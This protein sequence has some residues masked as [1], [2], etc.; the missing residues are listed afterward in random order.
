MCHFLVGLHFLFKNLDFEPQLPLQDEK[1]EYTVQDKVFG[2]FEWQYENSKECHF[3][4]FGELSRGFMIGKWRGGRDFWISCN[5]NLA[6]ST[7]C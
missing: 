2:S 3:V 4:N 1:A 6:L 7:E 5:S